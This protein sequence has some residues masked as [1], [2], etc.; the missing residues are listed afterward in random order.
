MHTS[1]P[2]LLSSIRR[3]RTGQLPGKP[4]GSTTPKQVNNEKLY[5]TNAPYHALFL[6][7]RD[8]PPST[9]E[10][11]VEERVGNANVTT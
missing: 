1:T 6:P 10:E 2:T 4:E 7:P 3:V 5:T 8:Q 11:E 9:G